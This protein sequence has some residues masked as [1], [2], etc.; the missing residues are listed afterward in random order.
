MRVA[1]RQNHNLSDKGPYFV[2]FI[3]QNIAENK[4]TEY[5]TVKSQYILGFERK[6]NTNILCQPRF[7]YCLQM[8][9]NNQNSV[10]SGD[11]Q[12]K[13]SKNESRS[14]LEDF[15]TDHYQKQKVRS[16][17]HD[18]R[19]LIISLQSQSRRNSSNQEKH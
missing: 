9:D 7:H 16:R 18:A 1:N 3:L 14:S 11:K 6:I 19:I 2:V 12:D 17:T 13:N 8:A 10:E 4:F 5:L 15:V